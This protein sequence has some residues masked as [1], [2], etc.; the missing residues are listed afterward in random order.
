[1]KVG[2]NSDSLYRKIDLDLLALFESAKQWS[3]FFKHS[4]KIFLLLFPDVL[5][6]R[7]APD[8]C[9]RVRHQGRYLCLGS[10][11]H[12]FAS[13][14]SHGLDGPSTQKPRVCAETSIRKLESAARSNNNNNNNLIYI[15]PA[16]R[17]TSEALK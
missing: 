6:V 16:C 13:D 7:V 4:I 9:D 15:A 1:V 10:E 5:G 17:M 8:R 11:C 12:T 2:L 14:C 3:L